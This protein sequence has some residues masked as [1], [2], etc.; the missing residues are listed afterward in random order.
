MSLLI[1]PV[2]KKMDADYK[3]NSKIKW[4][5]TKFLISKDGDMVERFEP[6]QVMKIVK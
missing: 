5:F 1:R 3:N 6:T 2:V 4:N